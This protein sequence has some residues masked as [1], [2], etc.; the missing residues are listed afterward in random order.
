MLQR[1]GA[2]VVCLAVPCSHL[3]CFLFFVYYARG[4]NPLLLLL[5]LFLR[6]S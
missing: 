5:L 6:L 4:Y 2:S 1:A 3:S